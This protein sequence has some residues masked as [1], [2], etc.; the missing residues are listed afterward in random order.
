MH[1]SATRRGHH[2]ATT[3]DISRRQSSLHGGGVT[4]RLRFPI[5]FVGADA[6]GRPNPT[7]SVS[8]T[9]GSLS[10]DRAKRPTDA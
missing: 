8:R 1:S 7:N 2:L 9:M 4:T 6:A 10:S 3:R 5:L